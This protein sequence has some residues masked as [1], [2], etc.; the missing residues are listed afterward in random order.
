MRVAIGQ[1]VGVLGDISAN[2]ERMEELAREAIRVGADLLVLPE[3][4]LTGYNLGDAVP[5]LAEPADGAAALKVA[6][7]ARTIGI[8]I[9]YGFPERTA[10]DFFSSAAL[11]DRNGRMIDCYRK[12][13]LWG[14][15][16]QHWFKPGGA[17]RIFDFGGLRTAFLICYD[18]DFPEMVQEL[19]RQGA[20]LIIAISATTEPYQ[21]VPRH[22]IPTRAYEN[23]LFM[24]FANRCGSEKDLDYVGESCIHA[25]DGS[26]IVQAGPAPTLVV[27]EIDRHSFARYLDIHAQGSSSAAGI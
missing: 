17:P 27:G 1:E 23:R 8:A 19:A 22:V 15:W 2:L 16:E 18:L 14:A 7:I 13:H 24:I 3:L 20:E 5:H 21:V 4:F 11:I 25:P 9:A 10:T 6:D 12:A 26:C